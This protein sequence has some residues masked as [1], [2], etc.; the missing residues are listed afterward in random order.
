MVNMKISL[1]GTGVDVNKTSGFEPYEGPMP[2]AGVYAAEIVACKMRV[3]QAGNPYFNVGFELTH[4]TTVDKEQYKG[5]LHW[6]KI[7]PGE[8]DIQKERVA[9]FLHTVSGK[10]PAKVDIS[11]NHEDITDGGKVNTIGGKDPVGTKCRLTLSRTTYNGEPD[12][13]MRDIFPWPKDQ[14]FPSEAPEGAIKTDDAEDD[15]AAEPEEV[16]EVDETEEEE[17]EGDEAEDEEEEG[18]DEEEPEDDDTEA[19]E[20]RQA[21][22]REVDRTELKKVLKGLDADFKVLKRHTDED[23]ANAILDI[24][25]PPVDDEGE[26]GDEP[27]F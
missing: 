11:V 5:F 9:K 19:F 4:Q 2:K 16:E 10:D 23:L 13:D 26:E 20:A 24:E 27:P 3:S 22:L 6:E 12:T 18:E 25:F 21:E 8:S 7:V 17:P 1:K 14:D 15:D